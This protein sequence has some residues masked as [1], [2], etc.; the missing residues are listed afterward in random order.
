M[1]RRI[2][3][4]AALILSTSTSG[5]AGAVTLGTPLVGSGPGR[6]IQCIASNI[7][8]NPIDVSIE[9]FDP[10]GGTVVPVSDG[11]AVGPVAAHSSCAATTSP[12]QV[13]GCIVRSKSKNVRAA[14]EVFESLSLVAAVP[15]TSR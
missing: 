13:V 1:I 8:S 14:I 2:V 7:G 5:I 10:V 3:V 6:V 4:S 12:G 15:A 11:C 9:L